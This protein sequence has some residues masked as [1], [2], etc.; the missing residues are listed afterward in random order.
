MKRKKV[1]SIVFMSFVL[2]LV[3]QTFLSAQSLSKQ[4]IDGIRLMREEEKLAR[5]VYLYLF[6]KWGIRIFSN[7]A[8]S[9]QT[10]MDAVKTI[11]DKYNLSDPVKNNQ[12]G[13]FT[14]MELKK[15]Y[16]ELT[17]QG[18][19]SQADAISVGLMIEE[20]D[21]SDLEKLLK[22]TSNQDIITVYENLLKGSRNHL[23]SFNK[24]VKNYRI[25]Y[26]PKYITEKEFNAIINSSMERGAK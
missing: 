20:L 18:S 26:Q 3:S 14:S 19:K 12:F 5:D 11:I 7:I 9:E 24:Q 13:S 4:E 23:R 10:H 17:K 1:L 6:D 2:L 15:L 22:E 21:I 16:D 25:N 8:K